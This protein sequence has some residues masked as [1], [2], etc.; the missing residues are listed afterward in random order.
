VTVVPTATVRLMGM[1]MKSLISTVDP[2]AAGAPLDVALPVA[3]VEGG[4]EP[5]PPLFEL[6]L[7]PLALADTAMT[8]TTTK[9]ARRG[10]LG[11]LG[12][13]STRFMSAPFN[14]GKRESHPAITAVSVDVLLLF[15]ACQGLF[16][17]DAAW[18]MA[19]QQAA[20]CDGRREQG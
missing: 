15:G 1:N 14:W 12:D 13:V 4:G 2:L 19:P 18:T 3:G 20:D 6:E 16:N 17:A 5:A 7:H 8:A 10:C 11:D 9:S